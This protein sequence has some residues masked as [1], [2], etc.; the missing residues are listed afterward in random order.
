MDQQ[1]GGGCCI[2]TWCPYD[3][4]KVDRIMLRFRPI[5]PKPDSTDGS[6][7]GGRSSGC[8]VPEYVGERVKTG[9]G[10]RRHGVIKDGCSNTT[11]SRR[12]N[13]GRRRK[14]STGNNDSAGS[15]TSG[16]KDLKILP[17][18]PEE[19]DVKGSPV[20]ASGRSYPSWLSLGNEVKVGGGIVTQ[21]ADRSGL[22]DLEPGMG[23]QVASAAAR[24]WVR[25]ERV[26]DTWMAAGWYDSG[27]IGRTDEEMVM[28][29]HLDTCPGF[30]T[31][32]LNRVRW[33]NAA[34][35][36]MEAA[37]EEVTAS[38]TSTCV[39][40]DQGVALP[41]GCAGFTCKARVL[42]CGKENKS[43]KTVPC[44]VWRMGCGWFAW[45]LDT[46]AA[47][48]LGSSLA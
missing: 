33:A 21:E 40:L 13:C 11:V 6:V 2:T 47:L 18:L 23:P 43:A 5:A 35:K 7:P 1:K 36:R 24:S 8:A 15:V 38:A 39:V 44:D 20:V 28:N 42:T 22:E 34:Y 46:A 19:P 12:S 26:T 31:D 48:C 3:M 30:I 16:G 45:R 17:L 14:S 37:E 4:S 9:C 29:L 25:V 10:K 41:V 27:G 32:G